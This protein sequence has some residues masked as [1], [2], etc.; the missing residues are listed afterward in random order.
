MCFN[1]LINQRA[2]EILLTFSKV[3]LMRDK[4]L[5]LTRKNSESKINITSIR[6]INYQTFL[7]LINTVGDRLIQMFTLTFGILDPN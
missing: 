1:R 2:H 7:I 3:I 5:D 6:I 4:A